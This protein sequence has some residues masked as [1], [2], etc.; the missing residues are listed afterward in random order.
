[1]V[2]KLTTEQF[3]QKARLIHGEKYDYSK[4][5]YTK[6]KDHVCIICN[7]HGEF[8]Q[9]PDKHL[10][11]R[12]CPRCSRPNANLSKEEFV[13]KAREIHGNKYDYTLTEFTILNDKVK[14][15]CPIHGVF[16][17]KACSHLSGSGCQRCGGSGRYSTN[18]FIQKHELIYGKKYNYSNTNLEKRDNNKICVICPEHGPYYKT[19][20][21]HF[22][23]GCPKCNMPNYQL[24][25]KGFI[26]KAKEIHG[27]KY[28]YSKS[29]YRDIYTKVCVTCYK[30]G[31]LQVIP[32]SFLRGNGCKKCATEFNSALQIQKNANDFVGKALKI[33]GDKYDYS[34]AKYISAHDRI[35]IIC[36]EHGEFWQTPN[37]HLSGCNCPEC[38]HRSWAYTTEEYIEKAKK[39]HPEYNYS[40]VQYVNNNTLIKVIC[41]VHGVFEISPN[42]LLR[43]GKCSQCTI[44]NIESKQEYDIRKFLDRHS[45]KYEREKQFSWLKRGRTMPL[46]FY[47]PD[48]NIAIECQG[49]QHFKSMSFFGGDA[50]LEDIIERDVLKKELCKKHGICMLYYSDLNIEYPY[51]VIKGFD[52]LLYSIK[53]NGKKDNRIIQ[54][55]LDFK[56]P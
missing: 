8:W 51:D 5:I 32:N 17:I 43:G 22:K 21:A 52:E 14:I 44:L 29:I 16:S 47:L 33:H 6:A 55:E 41:P 19:I 9:A 31:D 30:H 40:Q 35:C 28:S 50:G 3:I 42:Y 26:A 11:G 45:I 23:S 18:E 46:D 36:P 53:N 39:I 1:M 20:T 54:L 37:R 4:V 48:Y 56:N 2:K 7:E 27:D 24:D 10:H 13:Q 38:A 34:K 12:G 15:K 49:M 25:T